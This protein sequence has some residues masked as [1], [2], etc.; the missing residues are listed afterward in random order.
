M[1]TFDLFMALF[2]FPMHLFVPYTFT[3]EKCRECIFWTSPLQSKL[4]WNLMRSHSH[5]LENQFWISLPKSLVTLS[6]NLL[7]TTGSWLL[8]WNKLKSCRWEIQD[9][10]NSSSLL[11]KMATRAKNRKIVKQHLILG[12]W[13]DFRIFAQKCSFYAFLSPDGYSIQHG[14]H[15]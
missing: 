10:R 8:D 4:N 1:L 15:P 12:Q 9:G 5:H 11:N 7:C 13:S 3:W 14:V 2:C 6:R